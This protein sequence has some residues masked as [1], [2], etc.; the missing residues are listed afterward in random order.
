MPALLTEWTREEI[1]YVAQRGYR[2][3]REGRLREAAILFEG[4][5]IIDPENAYCR[6]ALAA[7]CIRLNQ[8]GAAAAHL[9]A[10]LARNHFDREALAGRCEALIGMHEFAAARRDLEVLAE[11]PSGGDDAR[12]LRLQLPR[13]F[14]TP[15]SAASPQLPA[16]APDNL[17]G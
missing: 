7:I 10:V 12:R 4:L 2:L 14:Q 11:L 6:K 3:Y 1:Y 9:D 5:T 13:D 8:Y 16:A 17:Y 15:P